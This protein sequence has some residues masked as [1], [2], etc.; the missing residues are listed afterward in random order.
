MSEQ[1]A[2]ATAGDAP[3]P[4]DTGTRAPGED[5]AREVYEGALDAETARGGARAV[6]MAFAAVGWLAVGIWVWVFDGWVAWLAVIPGAIALLLTLALL[7]RPK[8]RTPRR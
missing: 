1:P 2:G 4:G 6:A 8:R 7:P 3:Q 5:A